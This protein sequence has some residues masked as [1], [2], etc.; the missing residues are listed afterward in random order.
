MHTKVYPLFI[1]HSYN[2]VNF[3]MQTK[4]FYIWNIKEILYMVL[5][6]AFFFI[7]I[8]KASILFLICV[9]KTGILFFICIL[10]TGILFLICILKFGIL[11]LICI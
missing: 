10:K 3:L 1:D 7:G 9:L 4:E 5:E 6:L 2:Y 11:F 8:L